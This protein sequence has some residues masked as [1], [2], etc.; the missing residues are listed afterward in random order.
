MSDHYLYEKLDILREA[1]DKFE[2]PDIILNGLSTKI[3]L[4]SYQEAAFNN[5][6][7]Y[8]ENDNLRKNKQIHSLFHMATGSGK[9]VIMAGL[10]LYLYTKGYRNFLFFVNQTNVL[11]KTIENFTNPLSTKYLFNDVVKLLGN[12]IKIKKVSNFADNK[13]DN[14]INLVFTTTQKLHMD[15][16]EAKE[17]SLTLEDFEN[18]KVVFISDESHHV[19]SMTKKPTSDEKEAAKSWEYSVVNA[20]LSNKDN[21]LLEFTATCDLKDKNVQAKY[22]DKI[23]FNYPLISFRES[24]YTKDFQNFATDSDLWTRAL[25]A[26]VMSEYRKFLFSDLG[27]N[28]KPVVMFKSQKISESEDFYNEFFHKINELSISELT[29]LE[30]SG[31]EALTE[32][33]KYFKE[34]DE[35]Y[36]I[37]KLENPDADGGKILAPAEGLYL[38][39][40]DY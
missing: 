8:Y 2:L 23:V 29:D 11:E 27:L 6:I 26:I 34:K 35:D 3:S 20:F 4:R 24:G 33:I 22:L 13:L 10:I 16:F 39:R 17:N 1:S 5:F 14:N 21:I 36:I 15:L 25:M 37:K 18:N 28:I 38:Y 30:F 12:E 31:I 32:A 9:T 40:V 19:N 7:N